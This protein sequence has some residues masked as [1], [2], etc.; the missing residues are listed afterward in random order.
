MC[1]SKITRRYAKR[2]AI[3]KPVVRFKVFTY[4]KN[5]ELESTH[6]NI[7]KVK[8]TNIIIFN[9]WYEAEDSY[10]SG[11]PW[12]LEVDIMANQSYQSGFHCYKTIE[13]AKIALTIAI[14]YRT[15]SSRFAICKVEVKEIHTSG[16]QDHSK[17][18]VAKYLR[19]I[20]KVEDYDV[21]SKYFKT[22]GNLYK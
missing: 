12:M 16:I 7:D 5:G 21:R 22:E 14:I 3:E 18:D 15:D 9:Q 1:L 2:I 19:V 11:N 20:E 6:K 8:N 13:D 4:A 17:V 10:S